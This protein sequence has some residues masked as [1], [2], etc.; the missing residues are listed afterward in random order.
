MLLKAEKHPREGFWKSYGRLRLEG[1][2]W[3]HKRVYRIYKSLKLNIRRKGKRRLPA[4]VKVPL[5]VPRQLNHTWSI[6]FMHD[7][8]ENGR[9]IKT[10]NVIDDFNREILHIEIDYSLKSN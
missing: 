4:R 2:V 3:N 6:D 1:N 9:K 5:E 10:F 8:L 7:S